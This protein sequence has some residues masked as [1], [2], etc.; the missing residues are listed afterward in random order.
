[1]IAYPRNR[2]TLVNLSERGA[3]I[4]RALYEQHVDLAEGTDDQRRTLT[5][6]MAEQFRYELGPAYG[7]KA[8]GFGRP[9]SKDAIA[10]R[11][12]SGQLW[13]WDWQDGNSRKPRVGPGSPAMDIT[14][15]LFIDV[16][17]GV[18]HL[19]TTQPQPQPVPPPPPPPPPE[20]DI[21][22]AIG[23]IERRLADLE[24]TA[25]H[26]GSRIGLLGDNGRYV[27]TE[28]GEPNAPLRANRDSRLAWETFTVETD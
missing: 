14:G 28:L 17:P 26:H 6:M 24:R 19:G 15:Q 5:R 3:Q 4:I 2:R 23:A 10:V 12:G 7:T 20:G 21:W 11:D 22:S 18:D 8:A 13:G 27:C 25:V 1:M 9:Q 16:S